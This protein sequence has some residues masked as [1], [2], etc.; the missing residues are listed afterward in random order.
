MLLHPDKGHLQIAAGN[1]IP[2]GE[3]LHA[4]PLRLGTTQG[5]LLLPLLFN[6]VGSDQ[7][8]QAKKEIKYIQ[9][10]KEEIKLI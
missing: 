7:Y 1:L 6:I 5:R 10:G 4:F 3:R 8:N 2:T 9:I